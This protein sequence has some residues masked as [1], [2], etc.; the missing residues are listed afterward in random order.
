MRRD[1]FGIDAGDVAGGIM[2]GEL[3][4]QVSRA[5]SFHSLVNTHSPP[6]ASKPRRMPPIPA[7]RSTKRKSAMTLLGH[8]AMTARGQPGWVLA[9]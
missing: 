8:A 2:A 9:E 3:A 6:A 4:R 1:I 5:L 7:K